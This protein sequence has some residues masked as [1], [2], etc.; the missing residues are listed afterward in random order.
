MIIVWHDVLP[1]LV[2]R[3]V[4]DEKFIEALDGE[5]EIFNYF[6]PA[7]DQFA[8]RFT[9]SFTVDRQLAVGTDRA[10]AKKICETNTASPVTGPI[11][12]TA[13]RFPTIPRSRSR[14][15][16]SPSGN[17]SHHHHFA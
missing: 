8:G 13:R 12:A 5:L 7:T 1:E 9:L 14:T 4:S 11:A 16:R 15:A 2:M 3:V 10:L 17:V 6:I